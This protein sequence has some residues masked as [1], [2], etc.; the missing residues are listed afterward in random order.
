M[1][2]RRVGVSVYPTITEGAARTMIADIR[3]G[4]TDSLC[5]LQWLLDGRAWAVLGYP[6]WRALIVGE[7]RRGELGIW[8]DYLSS[9]RPKSL[10]GRRHQ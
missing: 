6:N 8:T 7:F 3:H 9:N 2:Y 10:R 1:L 4:R 5:G